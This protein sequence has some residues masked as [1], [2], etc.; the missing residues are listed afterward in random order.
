MLPSS[1]RIIWTI[2]HSTRPIDTFVALLDH[3]Q[4]R[5]VADVRRHPGSRRLPQYGS[6]AL[7]AALERR[8][9]AYA[10]IP[11]L[12]GRR[13]ATPDTVNTGWRNSSFRGYA[14][15]MTSAEFERG[16]DQLTA[17]AAVHRTAMMCA[18]LLWWRCHRSLIAD[19]LKFN[20]IEVRHIQDTAQES[21]HPYTAP[22]RQCDGRLRYGAVGGE[23][24][25]ESARESRQLHLDI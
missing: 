6:E 23:P 21:L 1:P 16:T 12:G 3:Y 4:I 24:L 13:R 5:A 18:E 15:H 2:G 11:E 22:A 7:S 25:R 8:G 14:D 20:G 19:W 9:I 17:L 10:W